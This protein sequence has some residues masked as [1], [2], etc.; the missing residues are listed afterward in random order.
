MYRVGGVVS[1]PD[2]VDHEELLRELS[3]ELSKNNFI[4]S[5]PRRVG[6]SSLL[7]ELGRRLS[8]KIIVVNLDVTAVHPLEKTNFLKHLGRETLDAYAASTGKDKIRIA[9]RKKWEDL[10][11]A[12][13]HI[14]ID[15]R[16]W[17]TLYFAENPDVTDLAKQTFDLPERLA[18]ECGRDFLIMLDEIPK[19]I[20]LKGNV[21]YQEDIDF[22]WTLR[23]HMHKKQ[24]THFIITGSAVGMIENLFRPRDS[25]FHGTFLNRQVGGIDRESAVKLVER[26]RAVVKI[27]AELVERIVEVTERWPFYLQAFSRVAKDLAESKPLRKVT[28]PDF[29]EVEKRAMNDLEPHFSELVNKLRSEL[30]L[31]VLI[32]MARMDT[33]RTSDIVRA[34]GRPYP[35]MYSM[36]QRLVSQGYLK[37]V[38]EGEFAFLDH[39]FKKWLARTYGVTPPLSTSAKVEEEP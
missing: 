19:L 27:D 38:G 10:M 30:Q 4:L 13:K 32:E 6:K 1:G 16:E 3:R 33:G 24:H 17:I 5:G 36:M 9:L 8:K 26:M 39:L 28:P 23:S 12:I 7:E 25:P 21:P 11:D 31:M 22:M 37:R 15:V 14:R 34:L 35:A 29:E 2:F 20:R 18:L